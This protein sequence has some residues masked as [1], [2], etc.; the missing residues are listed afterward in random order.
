MSDAQDSGGRFS[1]LDL[2]IVE[3]LQAAPR[4]PWSRVG[5]ALGVDATTVARRWDRMRAQGLA[6]VTAHTSAKS[7]A[8]AYV[9]VRCRPR[10]LDR[11]I[12]ATA[13]LPWVF[14]VDEMTGDFDLFLS[15]AAPDLP[16]LGHVVHRD[17]GALPGVL[18]TRTR[19]GVTLFSAGGDWRMRAMEPAARARL[20]PASPLRPIVYST[21]SQERSAEDWSLLRA[22][23]GDGRLGY[24]ELGAATG[25]SEHTARRRVQRMIRDQDIS[26]RCDIAHPSAGFRAMVVYLANVAHGNL[27]FT[28]N[29]VARMEQVRSCV[30]V[31]GPHNLLIIV[32]LHGLDGMAG[33]EAGLSERFPDLEIRD[34]AVALH[35]PKRMGRLLDEHGRA[36]R[37][38]P[39]TLPPSRLAGA[40]AARGAQ[41][42]AVRTR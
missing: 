23:G 15:L 26:F 12:A 9:E 6:W 34:R 31:S 24:T 32:W 13:E 1:E 4:A 41:S 28:G 17:I 14:S 42:G 30:S 29:A 19:L 27:R 36:V 39:V 8:V 16:T 5:S 35:S 7:A 25:M 37:P 38:V 33:F 40:P 21:R 20:P 10:A 22:L 2:A 11:I 18:S 3:A